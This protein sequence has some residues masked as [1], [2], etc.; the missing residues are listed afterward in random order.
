MLSGDTA[1]LHRWDTTIAVVPDRMK[2]YVLRAFKAG[3]DDGEI[4]EATGLD[5]EQ[6]TAIRS[7]FGISAVVIS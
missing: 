4:A 3:A 7:H 5:C 2:R 6:V 1:I